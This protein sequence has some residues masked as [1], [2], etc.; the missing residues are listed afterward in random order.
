MNP[1]DIAFL[2]ELQPYKSE[3]DPASHPLDRL[4]E[5][6][7]WDKHREIHFAYS[8]HVASRY[9]FREGSQNVTVKPISLGTKPRVL[10][11]ETEVARFATIPTGPNPRMNMYIKVFCEETFGKSSPLEGL[12]IKQTLFDI[13][14]Y[15]SDILLRFKVKIDGQMF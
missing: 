11:G 9:E 5:L 10:E 14:Q 4:R 2:K 7:N 1:F 8:V 15:V 3:D 6:S 12:W 13:G